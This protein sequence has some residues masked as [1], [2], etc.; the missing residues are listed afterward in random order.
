MYKFDVTG[1]NLL[2]DSTGHHIRIGDFGAAARLNSQKTL[3]GELKGQTFGTFAFMAPE[4]LRGESYGRSCDIWSIG[5]C[6][7]EMASTK[8]PWSEHCVTNH[9]ALIYKVS[10]S[11]TSHVT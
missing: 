3:T 10:T 11:V 1:E 4:V 5:C 2:V 8:R 7:I 9:L 6:V